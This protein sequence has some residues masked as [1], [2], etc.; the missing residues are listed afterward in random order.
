MKICK[1]C[2]EPGRTDCLGREYNVCHGCMVN[3]NIGRK[4]SQEWKDMMSGRNSGINNP[5]Y[6]KKHKNSTKEK[7]RTINVGKHEGEKN[8]MYSVSGSDAPCYGRTG[9]KHPMFGKHHTEESRMKMSRALKGNKNALG[10][11]RSEETR[12]NMRLAHA[13]Y[14][15]KTCGPMFPTIGKN[16]QTILD[17][18]EQQHNIKLTRQ[19]PVIGYFLDGYDEVNNVVY[20]VDEKHH[21]KQKVKDEQR[22][23]NIIREL[24][25]DFVIVEDY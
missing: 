1:H 25:C 23:N 9:D 6:G 17:N 7:L 8:H 15:E 10:C 20:E 13:R 11:E 2:G 14:I 18:I 12:L 24:Q 19:Y 16:E 3:S 22:K 5:F 4:H 21:L